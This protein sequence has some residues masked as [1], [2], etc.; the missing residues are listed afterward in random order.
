MVTIKS[1]S[2]E[3]P[4]PPHSIS[5]VLRVYLRSEDFHPLIGPLLE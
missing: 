3:V 2:T 5:R 4:Q 1:P